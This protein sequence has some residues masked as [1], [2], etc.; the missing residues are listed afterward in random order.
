MATTS[1]TPDMEANV[2]GVERVHP[3]EQRFQH[4]RDCEGNH[5]STTTPS[6]A[7]RPPCTTTIRHTDNLSAPSATRTAISCVSCA[8]THESTLSRPTAPRQLRSGPASEQRA[9]WVCRDN[10]S[11]RS[12]PGLD[13]QMVST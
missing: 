9:A 8:T 11:H 1:I 2:A 5:D 7:T 4:A 6:S 12:Q 13:R 3:E 10:S